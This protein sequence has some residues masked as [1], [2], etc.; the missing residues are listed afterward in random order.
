MCASLQADALS[1]RRKLLVQVKSA[2]K[3]TIG[4]TETAAL[5]TASAA[6]QALP[7]S[8]KISEFP[9]VRAR[10][11]AAYGCAQQAQVGARRAY[12]RI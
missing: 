3:R 1:N 11:R 10:A 6:A 2:L 7:V 5:E 9:T 8:R 12:D 4:R